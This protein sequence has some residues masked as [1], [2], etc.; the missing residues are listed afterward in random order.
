MLCTLTAIA[1]AVSG[2]SLR[3]RVEMSPTSSREMVRKVM[4]AAL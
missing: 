3:K 1:P 2:P 4:V